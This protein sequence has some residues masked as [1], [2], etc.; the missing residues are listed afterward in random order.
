MTKAQALTV[1]LRIDGTVLDESKNP[2]WKNAYEV[3]LE[4]GYTKVTDV[5]A[6]DKPMTRYEMALLL[7]RV[8][9]SVSA[10]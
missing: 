5:M 1:F 2:R 7:R 9:N 10:D 4:K 3:A 8:H 6:L